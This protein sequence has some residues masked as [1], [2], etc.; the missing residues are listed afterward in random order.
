M[1]S[2]PVPL[3]SYS[4]EKIESAQHV[5]RLSTP[6]FLRVKRQDTGLY[7]DMEEILRFRLIWASVI[8]VALFPILIPFTSLGIQDFL[9]PSSGPVSPAPELVC[10]WVTFLHLHSISGF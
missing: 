1:H 2:F 7:L 4:Q 6:A 8:F 5:A 3:N 9:P 10:S